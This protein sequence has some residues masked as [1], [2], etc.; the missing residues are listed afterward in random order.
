MQAENPRKI[1]RTSTSVVAAMPDA[2]LPPV[3]AGK[4]VDY[5]ILTL[6]KMKAGKSMSDPKTHN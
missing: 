6:N 4:S 2:F 1:A 5:Q 3:P